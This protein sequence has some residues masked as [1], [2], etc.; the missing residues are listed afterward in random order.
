[1]H[2]SQRMLESAMYRTRID[3]LHQTQLFDALQS[4]HR[5]GKDETALQFIYPD[6]S[7]NRVANGAG[8]NL[9]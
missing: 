1:V 8:H 4:L 5:S 6:S 7:M 2:G 9:F 3:R